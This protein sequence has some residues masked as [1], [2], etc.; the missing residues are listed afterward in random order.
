MKE[1]NNLR[2]PRK[3]AFARR[4]SAKESMGGNLQLLK[5]GTW[6]KRNVIVRSEKE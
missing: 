5:K 4:V 2:N 6:E 3:R 1:H